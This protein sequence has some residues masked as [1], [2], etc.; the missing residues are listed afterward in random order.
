MNSL[1]NYFNARFH[2]IAT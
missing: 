2:M 1:T